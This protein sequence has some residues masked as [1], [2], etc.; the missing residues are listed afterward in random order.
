MYCGLC[1]SVSK[2]VPVG[3]YRGYLGITR[4]GKR[5]YPWRV[6]LHRLAGHPSI[7]LAGCSLHMDAPPS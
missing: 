1:P 7:F 3:N 5:V 2:R 4:L 6:D